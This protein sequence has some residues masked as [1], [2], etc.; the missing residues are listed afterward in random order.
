MFEME[1]RDFDFVRSARTDEER[2][3]VAKIYAFN[4][5]QRSAGFFAQA[6]FKD[7]NNAYAEPLCS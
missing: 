1:E 2:A 6:I 7:K 4:G 3:H 5:L